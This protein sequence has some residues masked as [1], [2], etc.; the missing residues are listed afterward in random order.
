[1]HLA[2]GYGAKGPR[3]AIATALSAVLETYN[4]E[5]YRD[6]RTPD[7]VVRRAATQVLRYWRPFE[8]TMHRHD[9]LVDRVLRR[10]SSGIT[11]RFGD[12]TVPE[13]P[14]FL[15][16]AV[17]A[18]VLAGE[19]P[20]PFHE[21]LDRFAVA[22][23]LRWELARGEL[24]AAAWRGGFGLL[25]VDEAAV[26]PADAEARALKIAR[27][28]VA[29]LPPCGATVALEELLSA[30][31][32]EAGAARRRFNEYA[33]FSPP[34]ASRTGPRV[35]LG[36]F[37]ESWRPTL[38]CQ[39][40]LITDT[41]CTAFAH[42]A[43]YVQAQGGKRFR[44]L[45]TIAAAAAC[46]ADPGRA[47]GGAAAV[48]WLHEASLLIDDI[49]DDAELR[50][51]APPL[52]R[53]T[54]PIFTVATAAFLLHR[55]RESTRELPAAVSRA[56]LHAATELLRGQCLELSLP[57]RKAHT[58]EGYYRVA[59]AKT[60]QLFACAAVLGALC[61]GEPEAAPHVRALAHYGRE[62]GLAFQIIDDLLDYLGDAAALGKPLGGD[63]KNGRPTLPKILLG[64]VAT[65][66]FEA[67][68]DELYRSGVVDECVARAQRHIET[69]RAIIRDL[70]GSHGRAALEQ[71]AC[72]AVERAA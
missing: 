42:A 1:M 23:G 50:R 14:L 63:F 24:T 11:P 40:A 51:G 4:A 46:D 53:L 12:S 25:G 64:E 9:A 20:E 70:P 26:L 43:A 65:E 58:V 39:M 47:L 21:Q 67:S 28:A 41:E 69:A 10:L 62:V 56:L 38:Q 2:Q 34:P 35:A 33:P 37:A 6:G 60:A 44:G 16:A 72:A 8:T 59:G 22:L 31:P 27:D 15:R 71:F 45:L 52:H 32:H 48:E 55:C 7:E 36:G 13:C 66:G 68:R 29:M 17:A 49:V 54:T 61:V 30:P 18:A 19:V 57:E 3:R 5:L